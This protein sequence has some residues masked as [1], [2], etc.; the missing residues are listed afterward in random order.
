[1]NDDCDLEILH[2]TPG[3]IQFRYG[4]KYASVGGEGFHPDDGPPT[5]VIYADTFT[6]WEPPF[7][8]VPIYDAE[9]SAIL[10]QVKLK[11]EGPGIVVEID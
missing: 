5:Y 11:I 8:G 10:N 9:K 3:R 2:R 4:G 1:M 6:R 7:D